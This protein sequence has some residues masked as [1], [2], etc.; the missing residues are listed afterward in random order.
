MIRPDTKLCN[1]EIK[2]PQATIRLNRVD[3]HNALNETLISEISSLLDWTK[4]HSTVNGG[5][6]RILN[7]RSEGRHFCAGADID[8][9]RDGGSKSEQ[10][11]R[12]DAERLDR[13]FHGLW[14]HPCFTIGCVQ[15]V[16]LG[17]GAG[18]VACLDH[19]IAEPGTKIALS[20]VKLGIL[21]AV[22]GPYVYR[23]LGS[24]NFRRL[25]MLASRVDASEAL[26]VGFVDEVVETK[27]QF[28]QASN[29]VAQEVMTSA[30]NA[31]SAA[32]DL[33]ASLDTWNGGSDQLR[34]W[35]LD[36]TSQMRGSKEGQEGLS[37]F[38]EKREPEWKKNSNFEN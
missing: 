38:L 21:P 36:L 14:S 10:E 23:R 2:G 7:I 13:L 34:K 3:A 32:K 15:G 9:M 19:A 30:P 5:S 17:G 29:K 8:M 35:T 27:D 26:R 31:I 11:N 33:V 1:L 18:L 12:E 4:E 20:E 37:A 24:S 22:I 25:S 16:A 6:L 28:E